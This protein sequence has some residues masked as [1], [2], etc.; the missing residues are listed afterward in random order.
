M[1][2]YQ[3]ICRAWVF[4]AKDPSY[5]LRGGFRTCKSRD[6]DEMGSFDYERCQSVAE[7]CAGVRALVDSVLLEPVALSSIHSLPQ[8]MRNDYREHFIMSK[9]ASLHDA[10][11]AQLDGDIPD[12]GTRD[13]ITEDLR[14][15]EVFQERILMYPAELQAGLLKCFI[16]FQDKSTARGWLL[17][18]ADKTD[19]LLTGLSYAANGSAGNV[20]YKRYCTGKDLE[21]SAIASPAPH[22]AW[23]VAFLDDIY[24]N[25]QFLDISEVFLKIYSVYRQRT[26]LV[27]PSVSSEISWLSN[28]AEKRELNLEPL[29]QLFA[30]EK[31]ASLV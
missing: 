7:H 9:V 6:G 18:C 23:L 30:I 1:D 10:P 5:A 11:E 17:H 2:V 15:R 20:F 12:D 25:A 31:Y 28:Y 4:E 22:D 13:G 21:N 26:S 3:K 24:R 8:Q 14:E 29:Q 19:A 27:N 16:E